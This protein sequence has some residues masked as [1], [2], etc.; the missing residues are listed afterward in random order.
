MY[1]WILFSVAG[2]HDRLDYCRRISYGRS[3]VHVCERR[4]SW[5]T[6][7]AK[8]PYF[9]RSH[10]FLSVIRSVVLPLSLLVAAFQ[11]VLFVV[12]QTSPS[13]ATFSNIQ[14]T[15]SFALFVAGYF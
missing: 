3:Y 8:F 5:T 7:K 4:R 13:W 6:N 2:C 12:L 9:V 1:I 10:V 11:V 15:F 14:H